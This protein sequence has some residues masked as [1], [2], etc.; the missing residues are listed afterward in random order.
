MNSASANITATGTNPSVCNQ[1]VGI[2]TGVTAYRLTGGDCVVEFRNVGSTTW[3]RPA[4]VT[5]IRVLVVGGGGGGAG[6]HGGG[7]GGG[8]VVEATSYAISGTVGI[9]VGGGGNGGVN[10]SAGTSG[11]DSRLF[12][13]GEASAG[14][15]G[16]IAKGGGFGDFYTTST[17]NS[18]G[19]A[20]DGGSGGG[21]GVPNPF[22]RDINT[23]Y[24]N[25]DPRGY[26]IQSSQSQKRFDGIALSANF[27]QYGNSGA[28]GGNDGYW[29]GGGGGGAG[30]AGNRGGGATGQNYIGGAGGA[31]IAI[32]ITDA[33]VVYGGGGGGGGGFTTVTQAAGAGG[34][35]GGGA[36][37]LGTNTATAGSANTGGGGGG[38][39]YSSGGSGSGGAGGSGIVIVRYTPDTTAPT[40]TNGTSFSITENSVIASNVATIT[41]S[42]SVTITINSGSDSALFTTVSSD[43]TTSFIRFLVSPNFESPTDTGTNNV[44]NLSVRATD[45]A[46]N[47]TNQ[48]IVI[49]VTDINEAPVITTH[50]SNPTHAITQ[51]ENITSV[52]SFAAT[53]VDTNTTLT[54]S[55]S[56]TDSSDFV[57]NSGSGILAFA[58]NPDFEG[59]LDSDTNNVYV[60]VV[61]VSDGALTDTQTLTITITNTNESSQITAPTISGTPI[62]GIAITVTVNV[63]TAG[64]VRF[65]VGGKRIS[66]C[67]SRPTIGTY[68]TLSATCSWK[69][70]VTGR[71]FLTATLTPTDNTFSPSNSARSEFWVLKRTTSR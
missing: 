9:V 37:S 30:A 40:F 24:G 27:N 34:L 1:V 36:G 18:I 54:W 7:G 55:L 44:Y 45:A 67:L 12:A 11:S 3:N 69:P 15:T 60:L 20:G 14:A 6:R 28:G 5:S 10:A 66:S 33:S 52:A 49:T 42:E 2:P 4:G 29:A 19:R 39:G 23:P 59:P 63:N 26:G 53:D 17:A 68:P 22:T 62:K 50:S 43:T 8:G 16:L 31:G 21:S 48:S 41:I 38:G 64:K 70:A 57:I 61:A 25:T 32:S 71:Q 13:N 46:G 51:D 56:G 65:F 58:N 35:G 47:F